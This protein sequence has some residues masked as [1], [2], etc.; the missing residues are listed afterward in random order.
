MIFTSLLLL[1]YD[2][3]VKPYEEPLMNKLEFFNEVSIIVAAYHLPLFTE[4]VDDKITHYYAGWSLI[5]L[6]VT[7]LLTNLIVI[8]SSTYKQ[9]KAKIKNAC[10]RVKHALC[11]DP[12][13]EFDFAE[14]EQ[15]FNV[16]PP[17]G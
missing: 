14:Y 12:N 2:L 7:N 11:P 6:V 13:L 3:S 4:F 16:P 5:M 17:P 10:G 8:F 1:I 15:R 9:T